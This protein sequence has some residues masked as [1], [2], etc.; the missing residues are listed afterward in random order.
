MYFHFFHEV[1]FFYR[2]SSFIP[3]LCQIHTQKKEK[4][5]K[6]HMNEGRKWKK[7]FI[8]N[9]AY[10]KH[11][12]RFSSFQLTFSRLLSI[13]C[14]FFASVKGRNFFSFSFSPHFK[15]HERKWKVWVFTAPRCDIIL[16]CLFLLILLA[17]FSPY[18]FSFYH[19][20]R[21]GTRMR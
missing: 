15:G 5:I 10:S 13:F 17:S 6:I 7:I 4:S 16:N 2:C 18:T 3:C 20:W 1:E 9:P 14:V 8:S 12:L 19:E 11:F 21:D